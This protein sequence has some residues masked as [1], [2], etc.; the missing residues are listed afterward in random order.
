MILIF[1]NSFI[2]FHYSHA[3]S[4]FYDSILKLL[5]FFA[6]NDS[7]FCCSDNVRTPCIFNLHELY[8]IDPLMPST[9]QKVNILHFFHEKNQ[10][11]HYFYQFCEPAKSNRSGRTLC[12]WCLKRGL[13]TNLCTDPKLAAL[14]AKPLPKAAKIQLAGST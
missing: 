1:F 9:E 11:S 10:S 12:S 2:S 4:K 3:F 14:C 6:V 13:T 5:F 7:L 8:G